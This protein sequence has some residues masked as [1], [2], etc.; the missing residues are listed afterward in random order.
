MPEKDVKTTMEGRIVRE[1]MRAEV[2]G[3]ETNRKTICKALQAG[4]D[5]PTLKTLLCQ[6]KGRTSS[7]ETDGLVY[8]ADV[9]MWCDDF[10]GGPTLSGETEAS[11]PQ[12]RMNVFRSG[13]L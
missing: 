7:R 4:V 12:S 6:H 3:E 1:H 13:T 8:L 11:S 9:V 5:L 2:R 10:C